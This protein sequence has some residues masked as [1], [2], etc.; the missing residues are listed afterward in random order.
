MLMLL[1]LELLLNV[2]TTVEILIVNSRL[3]RNID[4]RTA[5]KL[6]LDNHQLEYCDQ[7]KNFGQSITKNLTGLYKLL[8]YAIGVMLVCMC[9]SSLLRICL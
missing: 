7:V 9:L 2:S 1:T 5:P 4:F 8:W 6:S 3:T